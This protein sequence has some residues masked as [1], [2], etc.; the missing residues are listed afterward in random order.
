MDAY[1]RRRYEG[2]IANIEVVSKEDLDLVNIFVNC[3]KYHL[4]L[5]SVM[6]CSAGVRT[7]FVYE[8][9]LKIM[10]CNEKVSGSYK[11][12]WG[13]IGCRKTILQDYN[14]GT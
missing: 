14:E 13:A 8:N 5:V 7:R 2:Q 10:L 6:F 9:S 4:I 11:V 1:L 3:T 12:D